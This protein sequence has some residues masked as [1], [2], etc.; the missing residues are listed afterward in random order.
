VPI[1][2]GP[3][4]SGAQTYLPAADLTTHAADTTSVHGITDTSVLLTTT[5]AALAYV[6]AYSP[7]NY[8]AAGDDIADDTTE[9]QACITAAASAGV[10][11]DLRGLTYKTTDTLTVPAGSTIRNGAIRCTGT[12]KAILV[13][14]G[15]NVTLDDVTITGRHATATYSAYEYGIYAAGDSAD[16]PITNLTVRNC[17]ISLVGAYGVFLQYVEGFH[18]DG[19]NISAIGFA[20][21]LTLSAQTGTVTNN[22]VSNIL[23]GISSNGYGISLTRSSVDSLVTDPRTADVSVVGN[24]VSDCPWEGI[25][26]HGGERITIT[27]NTVTG[28][29]QGIVVG[30]CD[31]A[32]SVPTYAPLNCS[33]VGNTV[34]SGLTDGTAGPGIV[35]VGAT[36]TTSSDPANQY[37]TGTIVGNTIQGHGL[38]GNSNS[39]AIYVRNTKGAVVSGNQLSEPSPFGVL[40][41]YDNVGISVSGN[42]FIDAWSS[43]VTVA[44]AICARSTGNTGTVVGNTLADGSKSATYVNPVGIR[45]SGTGTVI[46]TSGNNMAAAT[47]PLSEGTSGGFANR[48]GGDTDQYLGFYGVTPTARPTG[49][50]VS[51]AGVHAALV[52]L[53]LITA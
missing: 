21:V 39:G 40:L 24:R 27:G 4:S 25:D 47:D 3:G 18:V 11:V 37:A 5:A 1:S 19:N 7:R 51:A 35:L 20:G 15:S 53:G 30:S 8:D 46:N 16:D 34:D 38:Q 31:G 43:S 52:T 42:A 26:T 48:A 44:A 50:A 29:Y 2:A 32:G 10:A 33:V 9:L 12:T 17:T 13:V 41:Y 49:V 22:E 36:G 6:N 14:S 23:A 45:N 28:C